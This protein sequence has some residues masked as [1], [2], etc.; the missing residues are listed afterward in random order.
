MSSFVHAL[1]ELDTYAVA[2]F[3][4]KDG[5]EPQILLLA[6]LLEPDLEALIDI[7]LPFAEDVRSYRFPP[8][9]KIILTSGEAKS[10]HRFLPEDD[11]KEAMSD[12]VDSMDLSDLGR[13]D[14]EYGQWLCVEWFADTMPETL[15][16]T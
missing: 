3:V 12:F 16:S 10:K 6:P 8:L 4:K 11:L 1:A 2:R 14:E 9:D 7:P 5:A 15:Q 13:D